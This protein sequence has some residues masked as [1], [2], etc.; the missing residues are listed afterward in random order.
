MG[1]CTFSYHKQ[2][3]GF[4]ATCATCGRSI[5]TKTSEVYAACK[6]TPDYEATHARITGAQ[7]GPGW[8]LKNILRRWLRVEASGD[9]PCN[10]HARVMDMW[11]PDECERRKDEIVGWLREEHERRA[12]AGETI[13][14]WSDTVAGQFVALAIRRARAE[15]TPPAAA[16]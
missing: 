12:M 5:T 2:D 6:A 7:R 14:P 9:C 10:K 13:L 3:D 11:G 4:L 1:L 15:T 8:H 16:G